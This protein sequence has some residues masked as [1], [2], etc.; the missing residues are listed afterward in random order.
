MPQAAWSKTPAT[1]SGTI[2]GKQD[3]NSDKIL[4]KVGY[5]DRDEMHT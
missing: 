3:S 5:N 4:K 2:Y 1:V